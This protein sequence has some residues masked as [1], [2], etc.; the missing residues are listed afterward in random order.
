MNVTQ[1]YKEGLESIQR[2]Q[3]SNKK[4]KTLLEEYINDYIE[5]A[6][7]SLEMT[8]DEFLD[9][10]DDSGAEI[11]FT[12]VLYETFIQQESEHGNI[13]KTYL[14]KN[15]SKH[16]KLFIDCLEQAKE[17]F[18]SIYEVV[19]V[20]KNKSITVKDYL[21]KTKTVEVIGSL[22]IEWAKP[23]DVII[24][25]LIEIE[26]KYY[27]A[28]CTLPVS[29]EYANWLKTELRKAFKKTNF[30]LADLKEFNIIPL[31]YCLEIKATLDSFVFSM[32][33]TA[34]ADIILT[35]EIQN[36]EGHEFRTTNIKFKIKDKTR[37]LKVLGNKKYFDRDEYNNFWIWFEEV[38]KKETSLP[39]GSRRILAQIKIEKDR[40][41]CISNSEPRT[42]QCIELMKNIMGTSIG[43]PVLEYENIFSQEKRNIVSKLPEKD[44]IPEDV[45]R[46]IIEKMLHEN[47]KASLDIKIPAL[48]NKTPRQCAKTNKRLVIGWLLMMEEN[49][50]ERLPG[51]DYDIS[52]AYKE[53]GLT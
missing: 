4:W 24:A 38:D 31:K 3:R 33:V 34:M 40:L 39:T 32:F 29:H 7:D 22:A 53:L 37:V 27:F 42:K 5:Y 1:T 51:T 30:P 13:I 23:G 49:I 36:N 19:K 18:F 6:A 10:I 28:G 11:F 21:L 8:A 17:R 46:E 44:E 43:M 26:N 16:N 41:I 12:A 9:N 48:K 50:N 47:L 35:P 52:W 45:K 20:E 2:F 14:Q 25:K 15:K